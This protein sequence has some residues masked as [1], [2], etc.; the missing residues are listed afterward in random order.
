MI[1]KENIFEEVE[2]K[3]NYLEVLKSDLVDK[4]KDKDGWT[5]LHV[6]AWKEI[7]EVLSHPSVDQVKDHNGETPLHILAD[8]GIKETI[9]NS[10]VDKIKNKYG[11]TPLH[12]L[13][14]GD[15]LT[16]E[17]LRERFPWYKKEIKNIW[18]AIDEITNTPDSVKF[19][20]E[21]S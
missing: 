20:L 8:R 18:I 5:P 9:H 4:V 21:N 15:I 16:K 19:I 12:S 11:E 10:S 17:D 14:W 2:K 3:K 6:L 7:K 1:T 13:A